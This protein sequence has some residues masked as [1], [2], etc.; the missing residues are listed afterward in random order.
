[1]APKPSVVT[2]DRAVIAKAIQHSL[3]GEGAHAATYDVFSG[4]DWKL[5]GVRPENAPHSV[6]QLLNHMQY[7]QEWVLKWLDGSRPPIPK[8]ASSSWPG[9]AAPASRKTWDG[10][11]RRFRAGIEALSRRSREADLVSRDGAKSRLEMLQTIASHNSYHAGQVVLLRQVLGAWPPPSG[12]L[13][14]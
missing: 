4:L 6:Y 11:V 1:M 3:S 5:A 13:T 12:G 7:W 2:G 10:A 14:W 8:R 9:D